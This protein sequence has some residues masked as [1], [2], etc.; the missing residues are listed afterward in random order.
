MSRNVS[1][2]GCKADLTIRDSVTRCYVSKDIGVDDS[3]H[4][5]HYDRDGYFESDGHL[6]GAGLGTRH[7]LV[8]GSDRCMACQVTLQ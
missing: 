3:I 7:D 1:C 8:D 4:Q 6:S 5:G 2:P